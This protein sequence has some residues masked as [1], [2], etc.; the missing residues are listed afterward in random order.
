MNEID[1][2]ENGR[3]LNVKKIDSNNNGKDLVIKVSDD[4][5]SI[6]CEIKVLSKIRKAMNKHFP[7]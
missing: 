6:A 4:F 5:E 1:A 2:G 7:G 3:I